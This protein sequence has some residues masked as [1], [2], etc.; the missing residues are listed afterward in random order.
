MFTTLIT[1]CVGL[2]KLNK[3]LYYFYFCEVF[4]FNKKKMSL[5]PI[6]T[7]FVGSRKS[8]SSSST[9]KKKQQ[10]KQDAFAV[11]GIVATIGFWPVVFSGIIGGPV[12]LIVSSLVTL[13][14]SGTASLV[15]YFRPTKKMIK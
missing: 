15:T 1:T 2:N 8:S 4:N 10:R 14:I 11:G 9:S 3:I 12:G 13:V 5:I 6:G 7:T